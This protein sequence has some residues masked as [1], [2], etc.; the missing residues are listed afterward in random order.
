MEIDALF[1]AEHA[2]EPPLTKS[3]ARLAELEAAEELAVVALD[4][5]EAKRLKM[6][7][8]RLQGI[9]EVLTALEAK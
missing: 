9:K 5:D 8:D 2:A 6:E 4:F 7:I 1:C 3:A